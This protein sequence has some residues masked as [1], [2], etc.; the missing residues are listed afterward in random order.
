VIAVVVLPAAAGITV[1]E[2]LALLPGQPFD[3]VAVTVKLKIPPDPVGVPENTP[4]FGFILNPGGTL[5][6]AAHV[7]PAGENCSVYGVPTVAPGNGL[8]G[9]IEI[10]WHAVTIA[11]SVTVI[12]SLSEMSGN[13][14]PS[15]TEIISLSVTIAGGGGSDETPVPDSDTTC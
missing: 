6:L 4:V 13:E 14:G 5:P 1:N 9:K 15:V 3:A 12:V 2:T 8:A 10:V 11:V 7:R